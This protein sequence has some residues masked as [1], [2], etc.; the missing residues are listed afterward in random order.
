MDVQE[1]LTGTRDAMSA[2]RVF[3]KPYEHDGVV[4]IPAAKVRGMGGG[5]GGEGGQP[6][7]GTG[8]G[9]GMGFGLNARPVGAFVIRKGAVR[10]KPALDVTSVALR[11]Q[12]G[13]IALLLV[14]LLRRR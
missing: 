9:A 8:S 1:A 13:V 14:L 3:G 7:G 6:D 10:W 2:R 5:G 12:T 4:V 11:A